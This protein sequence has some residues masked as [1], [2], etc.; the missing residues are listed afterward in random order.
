MPTM[1]T[2]H[3]PLHDSELAGLR[4]HAWAGLGT[5][6]LLLLGLGGWTATTSI[7]GA[8]VAGGTVSVSG[9]TQLIQHPQGGIVEDILVQDGDTVRVGDVLLRLDG[10]VLHSELSI[11][12]S[13]LRDALARRARLHAESV[14]SATL[15]LPA[16][17]ADWPPD[18]ELS[19]LLGDQSRL[20]QSRQASLEGQQDQLQQQIVQ[21][22]EQVAGL[23]L[24][25]AA[26]E[27]Q[28]ALLETDEARLR[29]LL[30][31]GL[32][33]SSRVTEIQR[34]RAEMEGE[35]GRIG[36]AIASARALAGELGMRRAQLADN[37]LTDVLDDL[38]EVTQLTQELLQRKAVAEDRL[39]RL[40]I[41]AP[42]DGVV[43]QL[44]AHTIGGVVAT[45]ETIMQ[46][47]P[48][49]DQLTLE[50]K[51][52]AMDVDKVYLGQQVVARFSG[53]DARS[54]P[55]LTARVASIAPDL[56]RDAQ[57][58][59]QF[60]EV[61]VALDASEPA[62]LPPGTSLVPGMP[63]EVYIQT[64]DRTVLSYLFRPI[65]DQMS[66]ALRD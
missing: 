34:S 31:Q 14:Q 1:L 6:V 49:G 8:I 10:T 2:N 44:A 35:R 32:M 5:V 17:V 21:N 16:L 41:L 46:V 29:A 62:K 66:R 11:V 47:V 39:R 18:P 64:G 37:F 57:T 58:G 45:G 33:E 43:Y 25:Q 50:V 13:Q 38:G 15:V 54:P 3:S 53:F 48:G 4:R 51:I 28:L 30:Q 63:A 59:A 65:S 52:G 56:T 55:E 7:A 19:A 9:G 24:Q 42:V 40:D 26:I 12:M 60:Y 22:D 23:L 20:R 61:S 27:R 36:A